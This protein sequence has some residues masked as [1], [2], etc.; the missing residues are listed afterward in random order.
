[1]TAE[2]FTFVS[3]YSHV[4]HRKLKWHP[5]H[6]FLSTDVTKSRTRTISVT[7]LCKTP[8]CRRVLFQR[9][10]SGQSA[11]SV[12]DYDLDSNTFRDMKLSSCIVSSYRNGK[13]RQRVKTKRRQIIPWYWSL[14]CIDLSSQMRLSTIC[15]LLTTLRLQ[16]FSWKVTSKHYIL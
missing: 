4:W 16:N 6:K 15:T 1:M 14:H 5:R 11:E 3:P 13:E 12:S 2:K 10:E 8:S 9:G 7:I